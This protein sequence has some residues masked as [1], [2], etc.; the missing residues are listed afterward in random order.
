GA[1]NDVKQA[2]AQIDQTR[3]SIEDTLIRSTINGYVAERRVEPGTQLGNGNS[4]MSIVDTNSIFFDGQLSETQFA[5]VNK[6][7]MVDITVDAL[8]G[9]TLKGRVEKIY[10]VA[11]S[12]SRSFTAHI[13]LLNPGDNV[14][15][16]MFG[17]GTVMLDIHPNAIAVSKDA[18]KNMVAGQG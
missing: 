1:A 5:L 15:P 3:Q 12:A 10:P 2:R 13:R 11:A 4:V 8:P 16:Q 7:Q 14:R 6:G 17:R 18:V 9:K